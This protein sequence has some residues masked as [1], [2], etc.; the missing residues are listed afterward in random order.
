MNDS[1]E[2]PSVEAAGQWMDK[3]INCTC[4][5]HGKCWIFTTM[6]DH[7]Y[8][9]ISGLLGTKKFS[10]SP[11]QVNL[12]SQQLNHLASEKVCPQFARCRFSIKPPLLCS[13]KVFTSKAT[14][15][16][17]W[18]RSF[19]SGIPKKFGL[20]LRWFLKDFELPKP[21][22]HLG[23]VNSRRKLCPAEA[24]FQGANFKTMSWVVPPPSNCGKWRFIGIPY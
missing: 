24:V 15:P 16:P 21:L 4:I 19:T 1:H 14:F 13:Y 10:N 12:V 18:N 6:F 20:F 3:A 23:L 2:M 9:K 8:N 5:L 22:G 11:P 7:Q 17:P